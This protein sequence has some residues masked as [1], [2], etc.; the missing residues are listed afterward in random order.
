MTLSIVDKTPTTP[1]LKYPAVWFPVADK[2]LR[3]TL[4]AAPGTSTV[5]SDE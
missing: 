4:N 1:P 3:A 5:V 2:I